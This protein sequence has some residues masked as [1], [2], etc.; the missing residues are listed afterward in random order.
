MKT[1]DAHK[2]T[3]EVRQASPRR[4]NFRVLLVSG[5]I[6]VVVFGLIMLIFAIVQPG[7]T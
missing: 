6:I 7:S 1:Y 4:T 2:S 5:A 3:T